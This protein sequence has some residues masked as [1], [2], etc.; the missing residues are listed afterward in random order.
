MSCPTCARLAR[1]IDIIGT[2]SKRKKPALSLDQFLQRQ[3]VLGLWRDVVRATN[4]IPDTTIQ[5]EMRSFARM[6]FERNREITDIMM[7]RYLLSAGRDQFRN[8]SRYVEE[9]RM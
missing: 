3:R 2:L 4:K 7:I 8:M 9:M 6:E 5:A 1:H